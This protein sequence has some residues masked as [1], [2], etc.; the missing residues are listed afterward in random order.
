MA[1]AK[2]IHKKRQRWL[3]S[4]VSSE[5]EL[6]AESKEHMN[7]VGLHP[8]A[9]E[10]EK[11]SFPPG[12]VKP[13]VYAHIIAHKHSMQRDAWVAPLQQVAQLQIL[14]VSVALQAQVRVCRIRHGGPTG[15]L[16]QSEAEVAAGASRPVLCGTGGTAGA[17]AHGAGDQALARR[18]FVGAGAAAAVVSVNTDLVVLA[19]VQN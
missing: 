8:V 4:A 7:T 16:G 18:V 3:Q 6:E 15:S 5:A 10:R 11:H 17:V 2:G 13:S 9:L 19:A 1:A 14:Q 12:R